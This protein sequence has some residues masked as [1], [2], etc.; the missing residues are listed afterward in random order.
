[1]IELQSA[2]HEATRRAEEEI[3]RLTSMVEGWLPEMDAL[4]K[5][6]KESDEVT[7]AQKEEI[8]RLRHAK[9]NTD[10]E[11][12]QLKAQLAKVLKSCED[13]LKSKKT[14]S[15]GTLD[16]DAKVDLLR[17]R[18]MSMINLISS[19]LI[20]SHLISSHLILQ[21]DLLSYRF[22]NS[23]RNWKLQHGSES[24]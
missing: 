4:K 20:S 3:A 7:L 10:T 11:N 9:D 5:R 15:F 16:L 24:H 19:H 8:R 23:K 18:L 6:A 21:S 1:M 14:V 22:R 12:V 17:M 13:E 2:S